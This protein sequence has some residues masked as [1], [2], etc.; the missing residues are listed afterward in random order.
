MSIRKSER[1]RERSEKRTRSTESGSISVTE[2]NDGLHGKDEKVGI[3][4]GCAKVVQCPLESAAATLALIYCH[5]HLLLP[6]TA[7][8]LRL[9][10][11]LSLS[12]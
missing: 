5:H 2:V 12:L 4:N 8:S 7:L 10:I 9:I 1:E 11:H 6:S 3:G